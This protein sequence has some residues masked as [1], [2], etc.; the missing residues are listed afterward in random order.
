MASSQIF[1][2]CFFSGACEERFFVFL[3][4][5]IFESE[6]IMQR[7]LDF[8]ANPGNLG[9]YEYVPSGGA[10]IPLVVALHGCQ[11]SVADYDRGTGWSLLAEQEG[12]ALV[13]PQQRTGN[14]CQ[15]C[16]NWFQL[17]DISPRSGEAASIYSMIMKTMHDHPID[18]DRVF[19]TGL[20]A[21]GAMACALL[22]SFPHIFEAGAIIAGLPY[23]AANGSFDAFRAMS[24]VDSRTSR[25]WGDLV[26]KL[27]PQ[28]PPRKWPKVSIWHGDRD[29]TVVPENA[30]ALVRQWTDLHQVRIEDHYFDRVD[31]QSRH[32]WRDPNGKTVVEL[33]KIEGMAHGVPI[34]SK[35]SGPG[36]PDYYSLDAGIS[37]TYHIAKTWGLFAKKEMEYVA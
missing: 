5:L 19:I 12:F 9:M 30:A 32:T 29:A 22:A 13:L 6:L 18:R 27:Q 28:T 37:S 16:F 21:G 2:F 34:N 10:S 15:G 33:Y 36:L 4:G 1:I 7:I 20:S 35:Y 17:E 25:E 26:R 23:G 8:G 11:Q 31:G 24:Y 3:S 14:N